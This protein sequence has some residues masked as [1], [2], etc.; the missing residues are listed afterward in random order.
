[1]SGI[2]ESF[3]VNRQGLLLKKVIGGADWS[4][5]EVFRYFRNLL[6]KP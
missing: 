3:I 5:P 4:S 1:M 6:Q 2:P